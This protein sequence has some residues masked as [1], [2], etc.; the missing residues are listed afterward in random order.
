MSIRGPCQSN[1]LLSKFGTISQVVTVTEE[2]SV[3][4]GIRITSFTFRAMMSTATPT[5]YNSLQG[6]SRFPLPAAY[7][8]L[9]LLSIISS[10]T[11]MV[12]MP[13]QNWTKLTFIV[14]ST[15]SYDVELAGQ[16]SM[17]TVPTT[18]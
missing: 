11:V 13:T 9:L 12:S 16:S 7:C 10:D 3:L 4:G 17:N 6:S 2:I 18:E 15:V 5:E 14:Q 1:V 8:C